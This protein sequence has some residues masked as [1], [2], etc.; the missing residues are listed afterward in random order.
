[1]D[2]TIIEMFKEK[3]DKILIEKLLLD[4]ANNNDSLRLTLNNKVDLVVL[5]KF[6]KKIN[7][8]LKNTEI[9]YDVKTLNDIVEYT[10]KTIKEQIEKI[11]EDRKQKIEYEINN[12]FNGVEN[13]SLIIEKSEEELKIQIEFFINKL[14]YEQTQNNIFDS[15]KFKTEEQKNEVI[16]TLKRFDSELTLNILTS[17]T[18]RNCS[19]KNIMKETEEKVIELNEKATEITCGKTIKKENN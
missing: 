7:N 17:L 10:K 2:N 15:Y 9:D 5:V 16:S 3:N 11:L 8:V 12:N 4:L 19:L 13:L 1:M 18:E 14:I 6:L